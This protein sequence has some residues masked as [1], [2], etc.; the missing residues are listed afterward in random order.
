MAF[1]FLNIDI[2][3][4]LGTANTLVYVK[5]KGVVVREPSVVAYDEL[6]KSVLAVGEEA[7]Q[8]IGRTPGHI[9]AIRPMKDGVIANFEITQSM[10]KYLIGK[11]VN[12]KTFF[13]RIRVVV[14]VPST[15][16]DV[17]KR[18]VEEAAYQA[19]AKEVYILEEPMAAAI[20]AGLPV[21]QPYGSMV[22][23]MGGG[24]TDIAVISLGGIVNSISLRT[25][26]DKLDEAIIQ[27][28]KKK[29]NFL[30][31]ERTAEQAKMNI[32]YVYDTDIDENN[33]KMDLSGRDL[34]TGLPK[35]IEFTSKEILKAIEEPIN[36]IVEA[37]KN[38][39]EG[40]PPE[41]SS[42]ILLSGIV[43]T[44]GGALIKGLDKL[45]K[46]E[47]NIEVK[48]AEN[49]LE[50]VALGTGMSVDHIEKMKSKN[51]GSY[52]L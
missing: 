42:D 34:I 50:C 6:D 12:E 38:T 1:N 21:A 10:L 25:A 48:V 19:G 32:G 37:V 16:T 52:N 20:G 44:G 47:T 29:H 15:V 17:E 39:L 45:L 46:R 31:G 40:A 43:L 28:A 18:A 26:G 2:G 13:S 49:P 41:L 5:N 24:T 51:T 9:K 22:V 33:S 8:M 14:G 4:D 7:K 27:Y 30:I 35:T 23:D 3:V 36:S 11:A